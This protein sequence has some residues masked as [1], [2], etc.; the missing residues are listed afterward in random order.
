[1]GVWF[2]IFVGFLGWERGDMGGWD[3]RLPLTVLGARAQ[4][5]N[6]PGDDA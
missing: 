4:E 3:Q 2:V 5:S 6:R 1:M